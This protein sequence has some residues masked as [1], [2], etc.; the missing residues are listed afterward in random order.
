M[1]LQVKIDNAKRIRNK[2]QQ[3]QFYWRVQRTIAKFTTII[4]WTR[5][6][7]VHLL[8]TRRENC[9]SLYCQLLNRGDRRWQWRDDHDIAIGWEYNAAPANKKKI[10]F[11]WHGHSFQCWQKEESTQATWRQSERFNYRDDAVAT[12]DNNYYRPNRVNAAELS[13]RLIWTGPRRSID[14]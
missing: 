5:L 4:D 8:K 10:T 12:F 13:I 6:G 3:N 1:R 11:R 9:F 14:E 2:C 7:R